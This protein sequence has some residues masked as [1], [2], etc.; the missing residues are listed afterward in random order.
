MYVFIVH[1]KDLDG[2]VIKDGF[3]IRNKGF[4]ASR[5]PG[6]KLHAKINNQVTFHTNN[7]QRGNEMKGL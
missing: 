4:K 7:R 3:I 6:Q 2:K 5:A 1:K